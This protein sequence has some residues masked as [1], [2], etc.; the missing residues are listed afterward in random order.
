MDIKMVTFIKLGGMG[1][2]LGLVRDRCGKTNSNKVKPNRFK[3]L[4]F[5]L[6]SVYISN[7]C[8]I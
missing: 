4:K 7:I 1:V 2:I 6:F 3:F 5:E 8:H